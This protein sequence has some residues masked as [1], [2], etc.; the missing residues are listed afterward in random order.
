M[1]DN[2]VTAEEGGS[3]WLSRGEKTFVTKAGVKWN[4]LVFS[5]VLDLLVT[6]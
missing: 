6:L 3:V 5:R 4:F 1:F 2:S